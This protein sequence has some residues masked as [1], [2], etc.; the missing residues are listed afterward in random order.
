MPGNAV[1]PSSSPDTWVDTYG[2]FLYGFAFYRVQ[3]ELVA[4]ELGQDTLVAA[5]AARLSRQMQ[6]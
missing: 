2:D 4:H 1:H 6:I 3:D 5:L